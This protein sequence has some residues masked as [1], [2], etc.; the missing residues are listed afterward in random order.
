MK[1]KEINERLASVYF[2]RTPHPTR[3]SKSKHYSKKKDFLLFGAL[4]GFGFV[5]WITGSI[6][7][8][9]PL[10]QNILVIQHQP[11]KIVYDFNAPTKTAIHLMDLS[12]LKNLDR[13]YTLVFSARKTIRE[14]TLALGVEFSNR[15]NE[16]S[17]VYI[18]DV[19][20]KWKDFRIPFKDFKELA[21]WQDGLNLS[22]LLEEWNV[23]GK[24]GSIY[25]DN[26]KFIK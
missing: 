18:R 25:I 9:K 19:D 22:F 24:Q 13:S 6:I 3:K 21:L 16:K 7:L 1:K 14:E 11:V 15:F 12:N 2:S 23:K 8:P 26:V 17:K 10:N 5:I 4:V 20:I